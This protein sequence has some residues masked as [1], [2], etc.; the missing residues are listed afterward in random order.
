MSAR[1]LLLTAWYF[2]IRVLRWEDAVKMVYEGSVDVVAEYDEEVRSPSVTW[3]MPAVIRLRRNIGR[4]KRGVKFSRANVYVRDDF[5]CQYCRRKFSWQELTYDHVVPRSRGG[6]TNFLNVVTACKP[7]NSRKA[8]YS[9]DELGM[10]PLRA[11]YVPKQLALTHTLTRVGDV[12]AEWQPFLAP[13]V[14]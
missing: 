1:T 4:Y 13:T 11:P 5:T 14:S 2:P 9:C 12:P 10:F 6:Q 3:K 7:C 8:N